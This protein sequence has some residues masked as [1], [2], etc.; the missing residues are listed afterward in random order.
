M[1]NLAAAM[2]LHGN[3]VWVDRG[4]PLG[5]GLERYDLLYLVGRD[6]FQLNSEEM[7]TLYQYWQ[8]GG[9]IFYEGCR[10]NQEGVDPAADARF[11]DLLSSFG[12]QLRPVELGHELLRAPYLF[13]TAP[14]GFETRGAPA[15]RAGER[16]VVSTYDYGCIWRGERRGR[17]AAR[18]EIRNAME[19]GANLVTWA[20]AQRTQVRKTQTA[21]M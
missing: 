8:Q 2:R 20:A 18:S 3:P 4:I 10:R 1:A 13:G 9:V 16:I 11:F 12:V 14:D 21:R 5:N 19:W 15:L 6:A 17:P 7:N